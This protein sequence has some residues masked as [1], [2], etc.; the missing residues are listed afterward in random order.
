[1]VA[2]NGRTDLNA[3]YAIL[4]KPCSNRLH[5]ANPMASNSL[6]G[7]YRVW[8]ARRVRNSGSNSD[9]NNPHAVNPAALGRKSGQPTR[10][11][12]WIISHNWGSYGAFQCGT[13][14]GSFAPSKRLTAWPKNTGG[15]AASEIHEFYRITRLTRPALNYATWHWWPE[16]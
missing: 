10:T 11:R 15:Y 1:M 2:P 6:L 3:L 9:K 5:G 8:L 14:W 13:T 4:A 7:M 16:I 12:M